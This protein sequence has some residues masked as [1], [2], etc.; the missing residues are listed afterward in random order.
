MKQT[1]QWLTLALALGAPA[2]QAFDLP[3]CPLGGPPGWYDRL[4]GY[5][6]AVPPPWTYGPPPAVWH[7]PAI[8]AGPGPM[9][10]PTSGV[11]ANPPAQPVR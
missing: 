10:P 9:P 5:R 6:S 7:P 4:F 1:L 3:F 11:P 8:T 2:T